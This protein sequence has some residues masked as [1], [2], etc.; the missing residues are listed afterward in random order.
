VLVQVDELRR[1]G[2]SPKSGLRDCVGRADKVHDGTVVVG[3]GGD[4][5]DV[6]PWH[7]AN[8][9]DNGFDHV[10]TAALAKIG[11]TLD[12]R[13]RHGGS[14]GTS[15]AIR[16]MKGELLCHANHVTPKRTMSS[17]L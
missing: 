2:N 9:C 14:F 10:G 7:G 3:V 1:L 6:Y 4:V 17:I 12:E 16:H 8:G 15:P 11:D 5:E 13:G